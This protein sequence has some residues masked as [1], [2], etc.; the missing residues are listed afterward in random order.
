[1][2]AGYSHSLGLKADGSLRAWGNNSW[3]QS[4]VPTPNTGFV[5]VEGGTLHSLA[6]KAFPADLDCNGIVDFDDINPFILALAD[7]AA[8]SAQYPRCHLLNGD[9]DG[10]G[11]VDFDDINPFIVLLSGFCD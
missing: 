11:Y 5:A 8:Y 10:N 6:L 7:P 2:A 9:C 1:M 4:N 3:G